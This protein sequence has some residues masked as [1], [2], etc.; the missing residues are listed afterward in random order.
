MKAN[1]QLLCNL[2]HTPQDFMKH[3]RHMVGQTSISVAYG[4]DV[5]PRDDP[6]I[7]LT[8]EALQGV[9]AAQIKGRIFNFIPFFI[10]FPSWFPGAGFKKDADMYKRKLNHCRDLPYEF[11][12]T[13][14]EE[15]KAAPSIATSMISALSDKSTPE[16]ILMAR[17]LPCNIY[18]GSID[19][20]SAAAQSFVLAM[21]LYPEV[22][23]RAQEEMDR[24][25]GH[26]HLPQFE[27]EDALPYLKAVRYELMRWSP[28][29]PLGMPHR[30]TEDDIYNGYCIPA[31][32]IV[33]ANSWAILHDPAIY[34]EPSKF[35]PERFLDPAA[36]PPYPE[37]AFGYGRRKC[38]GRSLAWDTVWITMASML[39][40]FEFL[41]ATDAD[42]RPAPP[43]QEF[44]PLFASGPKPFECTI[45]PRSSATRDAVLAALQD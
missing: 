18:A 13:A 31:G 37:A 33:F 40:A 43:A 1:R 12:K 42:G 8:D 6:T 5:A 7:T 19:T 38:P 28:P 4:I 45:R 41:P 25:L 3:L 10:H 44:T 16:E 11:V 32:S 17:A 9:M 39:A 34:P 14:L 22:Q 36:H 30:L 21:V 27:D 24:V 15:N 2:L 35:K 26:G 20:S 29:G 23:K